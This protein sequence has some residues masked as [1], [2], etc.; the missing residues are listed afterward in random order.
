MGD[1]IPLGNRRLQP[2]FSNTSCFSIFQNDEILHK[3]DNYTKVIAVRPPLE[4]LISAYYDKIHYKTDRSALNRIVLKFL[5]R[6]R[7]NATRYD[8]TFPVFIDFILTSQAV[9]R[10]DH[11]WMPYASLCYPCDIDYDVI[12]KMESLEED[13]NRFLGLIGAPKYLY[14]PS[15]KKK[16]TSSVT[17]RSHLKNLTS[18]QIAGILKYYGDDF[19]LFDYEKP[20]LQD[21]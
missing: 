16:V 20:V 13:T 12:V 17:E 21:N 19:D 11:H 8:I 10:W 2:N 3:L 14:Y 1:E 6:K 5:K 15:R 4:R 18:E 7:S 9:D